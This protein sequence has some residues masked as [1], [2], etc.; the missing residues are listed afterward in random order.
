MKKTLVVFL[1]ELINT[2]T[3]RSFIISMVMG[4][5]V[6]LIVF[7]VVG[8]LNQDSPNIV[9]E[10]FMPDPTAKI[11][12]QGYVDEAGL[13]KSVP[14][15]L[16]KGLKAYPDEAAARAALK[17]A[18]IN[19]FYRIPADYMEEKQV[20]YV[21]EDFNPFGGMMQSDSFMTLVDYNVLGQDPLLLTRVSNPLMNQ[22]VVNL[23][24]ED[25]QAQRGEDD[26]M[27]FMLPYAV[28]M[29]FYS[30]IM[31]SASLMANSITTEKQNR[32]M[33]ILLVAVTP[34]QM[35]AG[36]I[37]ALGVAGLAQMIFWMGSGYTLLL[38]SGSAFNLGAAFSLP[39]SFLAWG[40]LFFLL[41]YFLYASL[42]A[43]VG[44][45]VPNLRETSQ[46]TMLL[47]IPLIIPLVMIGT[48]IELPNSVLS[49]GLSLFPLTAPVT[50]MTRM[51]ATQVPLW[52]LLTAV[53]LLLVTIALL[54]R[55]VAGLFRAQTL[56]SGQEFSIKL[57]FKALFLKA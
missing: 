57:F 2:L 26:I 16:G 51:A 24:P 18:E 37:L 1:N 27:T 56:L 20:Y 55:G 23:A 5:I 21:R 4:P 40:L 36:K 52:Q 50:M 39:L 47:V 7:L 34:A 19:A 43:G 14:D 11:V 15:E 28:T 13:I 49:I 10:V 8:A 35:L 46:A 17:T 9:S 31:A 48:I 29:L 44:A 45:M 42:M 54:I 12:L 33:E 6:G 38:V 41:G 53:V 25:P 32:V 3:K 30:M 22:E